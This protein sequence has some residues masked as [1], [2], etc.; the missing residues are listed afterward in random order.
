MVQTGRYSLHHIAPHA[1]WYYICSVYPLYNRS[2]FNA[3]IST[4]FWLCVVTI[5]HCSGVC[6]T[7]HSGEQIRKKLTQREG[8]LIGAKLLFRRWRIGSLLLGWVLA[9]SPLTPS[10]RSHFSLKDCKN[11]PPVSCLTDKS[12]FAACCDVSLPWTWPGCY[13]GT[14]DCWSRLPSMGREVPTESWD[15]L[16][17]R[18]WSEILVSRF[19]TKC[20]C[21][22]IEITSDWC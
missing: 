18:L 3:S 19:C 21:L 12:P 14:T 22:R 13:G 20:Q 4:Y 6:S 17:D 7:K 11:F 8:Y 5:Y 1:T 9:R 15:S 10:Q 2:Y 16:P